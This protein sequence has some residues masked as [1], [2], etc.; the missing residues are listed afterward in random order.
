[1]KTLV[2]TILISAV[3]LS[4]CGTSNIKEPEFRDVRDISLIEP[5]LLQSKV[6]MDF[7]FY[8]PNNFGVQVADARGDVYIDNM[9]LGRI[10]LFEKVQ[11][12]R[13]SEFIVPAII[14]LDMIGLVK[15]QGDLFKKKEVPVRIEG[16]A[17]LQKS[18]FSREVPI[19]FESV[20]N[21]ERL[22]SLI[23]P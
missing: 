16:M 2:F 17:H 9:Y 5:G 3:M 18:G 11:V 22:R 19:H 12:K 23:S 14:Q 6:G 4:A 8:N 20:E 7:I 21:I 15:N 1:M 10:N 13:R